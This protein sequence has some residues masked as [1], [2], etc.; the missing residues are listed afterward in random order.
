METGELIVRP[1]KRRDARAIALLSRDHVER[2][3][4]WRYTPQRIAA[5]IAHRE[6]MAV[7]AARRDRIVGF[8]IM[9]FGDLIAHLCLLA[10]APGARRQGTGGR[11][12]DWLMASADVAGIC[13]VRLEVRAG[14]HGARR[15]YQRSG[16]RVCGQRAGYYDGRETAVMMVRTLRPHLPV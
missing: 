13:H 10:V 5:L 7:V 14:N 8:A 16:F 2:G 15:F 3:L 9:E 11:L 12:L 6:C 4:D 1:A